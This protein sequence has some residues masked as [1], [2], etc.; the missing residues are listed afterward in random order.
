MRI[1]CADS[2]LDLSYRNTLVAFLVIFLFLCAKRIRTFALAM[3][4]TIAPQTPPRKLFKPSRKTKTPTP[5][6]RRMSTASTPSVVPD[7]TAQ[8]TPEALQ[9][10]QSP[11]SQPA[12]S[13]RSPGPDDL[14]KSSAL[15][16]LASTP[17]AAS[18]ELADSS[19]GVRTGNIPTGL[20]DK[21]V[22]TPTDSGRRSTDTTG[23]RAGNASRTLRR[24]LSSF[25]DKLT[26]TKS[27]S[28]TPTE[29]AANTPGGLIEDSPDAKSALRPSIDSAKNTAGKP[30]EL[31]GTSTS[32]LPESPANPPDVINSGTN[33]ASYFTEQGNPEMTDFVK[34]LVTKAPEDPA[35]SEPPKTSEEAKVGDQAPGALETRHRSQD[36][37]PA[38]K[39]LNPSKP[40]EISKMAE[41]ATIDGKKAVAGVAPT[42]AV[43]EP[44]TSK[45]SKQAQISTL[46]QKNG[47][48]NEDVAATDDSRIIDNMG[49]PA[50]IERRIEIPLPRP[51]RVVNSP[52]QPA[53]PELG[54]ISESLGDIKDLQS[55]DDLASPD[56]LPELP[57]DMSEDPPEE[58]LDPSVHS[59]S[60]NITPIPRI[61][62]I[63]SINASPPPD[64]LQLARGLSGYTVDDVGNVVD[65]SGK[66]LGHV[67]GDLPAMIGKKVANNGEVYGDGG[68]IIGYVSENFTLPPP[69]S[70]IPADVLGGLKVDHQGNILDS[71]GNTIGRFH[72]KPGEN[73][74]LP[75][76]MKPPGGQGS[77]TEDNPKQEEKPKVNAHTGGSPSDIFLDVKSTTDGIQLTIRIPTTFGRQPPDE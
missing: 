71:D 31:L 9:S 6:K 47:A 46:G 19:G 35:T 61:P 38:S 33:I 40:E 8:S 65:N 17:D 62:K 34:A 66:V 49:Q 43:G 32:G 5:V 20:V 69:P 16:P 18:N 24:R 50:H 23:S 75:S 67:T 29:S 36:I 57:D 10:A 15:A 55:T 41:G 21:D 58:I 52:P 7:S 22:P 1:F 37:S 27:N 59:T 73:G 39:A 76:F 56:D 70:D 45:I 13:L 48:K 51:E 72:Q 14:A 4:D 3:A 30:S 44:D 53:R 42:N 2:S 74:S 12:E 54:R 11:V 68:E 77:K 60:A 64:L 26:R 25:K 63:P 28:K